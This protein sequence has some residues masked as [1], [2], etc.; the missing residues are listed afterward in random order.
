MFWIDSVSCC[1]GF[2]C[3]QCLKGDDDDGSCNRRRSEDLFSSRNCLF[4]SILLIFFNIIL[5]PILFPSEPTFVSFHSLCRTV[6]VVPVISKGEKRPNR[7]PDATVRLARAAYR[8]MES[9]SMQIDT[10]REF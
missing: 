5:V 4:F 1:G 10:A 6:G 7:F 9:K 3:Y 2:L 8:N